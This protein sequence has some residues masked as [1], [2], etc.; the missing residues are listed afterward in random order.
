MGKFTEALRKAAERKIEQVEKKDASKAYVVRTVSD[1]KIDPHVVAYFDS[2]SPVSEQYRILRTHLMSNE[3]KSCPRMI[4]V[5]SSIHG[6]GKTITA[7]NLAITCAR[8]LGTKGILVVDA[9]MRKGTLT[10]DLGI[11]PEKGLPEILL[12][13]TSLEEAVVS[14]GIDNL[15]VLPSVNRPSQPAELLGSAKMK[16]LIAA[17]RNRYDYVFFDCP[18][19]VPVADA[20]ILGP[21]CD[22]ILMVV[23]AGR[24]QRG[25]ITHAQDR[26][27]IA[28]ARILGYV[29]TNIEYHIPE[30]IYR[31]L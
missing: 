22:G 5:T 10:K 27:N 21:M 29:M 23:Q 17:V 15:H 12:N 13:G 4:A 20:T 11:K 7:L 3:N 31:Y 6:E 18:P 25:I 9:D 16:E 19:I 24:T 30:Y 14:I 2:S 28:K 1:S 8:D 26:L